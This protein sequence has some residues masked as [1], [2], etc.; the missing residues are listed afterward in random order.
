M[1]MAP[2]VY[3]AMKRKHLGDDAAGS[4]TAIALDGSSGRGLNLWSVGGDGEEG[5]EEIHWCVID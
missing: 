1:G 3:L 5:S 2:Y 4:A